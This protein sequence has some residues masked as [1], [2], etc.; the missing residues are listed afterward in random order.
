MTDRSNEENDE[1]E[2]V[3]IEFGNFDDGNEIGNNETSFGEV[4]APAFGG[5]PTRQFG[6]ANGTYAEAKRA[7]TQ[8]RP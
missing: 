5:R 3:T 7:A 1:I 2:E 6:A 8:G 4:A